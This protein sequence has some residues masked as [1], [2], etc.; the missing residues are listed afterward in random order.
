MYVTEQ[1]GLAS[2]SDA[3]ARRGGTR[4]GGRSDVLGLTERERE[5][6]SLVAAGHSNRE[7]GEA[8]F[9]TAK[10]ASVHVTKL[11]S[12]LQV[13]SRGEAAALA[14]RLRLFDAEAS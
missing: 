14:H 5:V 13:S 11:M 3:A 6:L 12:K 4:Q 10:T 8:L 2:Q 1:L 7:I 9:T